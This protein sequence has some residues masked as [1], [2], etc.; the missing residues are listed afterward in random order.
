MTADD[1]LFEFGRLKAG[2][3]ALIHAGAGGVGMAGIQ[4]AK[5]AGATVLATASSDEKLERLAE[6]GLDHGINYRARDFVEAVRELTGGRGA[7]VVVDS[8]GGH[9]LEQSIQAAAYRG[10]ITSVGGAGRDEYRPDVT[11]LR[12]ANKSLIGIFFGAELALHHDRVHPM[13]ANHIADLAKGALR[14]VIDS[15]FPLAEAAEAHRRIESR[16]AFGR[17]LLIP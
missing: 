10:R 17:V 11:T 9:V 13:V 2:E 7:D 8:I 5:R 4:L 16:L 14:V 12:P 6:F 15:R 1:C 3:T